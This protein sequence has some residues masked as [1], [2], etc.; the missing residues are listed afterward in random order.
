[1]AYMQVSETLKA[2]FAHSKV[3]QFGSTANSL[4]IC[5]NNDM[6]VCLEIYEPEDGQVFYPAMFF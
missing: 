4:C 3:H 1:M 6:D 2:H 5:G